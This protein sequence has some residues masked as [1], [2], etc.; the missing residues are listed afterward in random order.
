MHREERWPEGAQLVEDG[1]GDDVARVQDEVGALEPPQALVRYATR[2]ARQVRIRD[3]GDG[4]RQRIV[5]GSLMTVVERSGFIA[6][7]KRTA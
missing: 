1:S 5:N 4:G 3:D 2:P 6:A 7:A